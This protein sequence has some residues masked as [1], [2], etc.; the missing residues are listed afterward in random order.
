MARE[1]ELPGS[2]LSVVPSYRQRLA[3]TVESRVNLR[4]IGVRV[5]KKTGRKS[6][7]LQIISAVRVSL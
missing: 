3:M 2:S 6:L 1:A 7:S 5:P 4:Q